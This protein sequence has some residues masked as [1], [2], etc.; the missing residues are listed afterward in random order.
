MNFQDH[1]LI[2]W[3]RVLAAFA[4]IV[5]LLSMGIVAVLGG[6]DFFF[7]QG[8]VHLGILA[9]GFGS[10]VWLTIDTEV[11]N[12]VVWALVG[13]AS[14]GA[15]F[16]AGFAV[17]V[18]WGH[19]SFPEFTVDVAE[20]LT[21]A[22]VPLPVALAMQPAVWAWLPVF[23]LILALGLLRF[24]DGKLPSSRWRWASRYSVI[25]MSLAVGFSIWLVRPS[26]TQS[27]L[28]PPDSAFD[29][30]DLQISETLDVLAIF[31]AVFGI[32]ALVVR[33][34]RSSGIVRRQ[35]R[36]IGWGAT[37]LSMAVI[38]ALVTE[39]TSLTGTGAVAM[40]AG[41]VLLIA[42]F[43]MAITKYRLYEI[44]V[45]VSRTV[46]YLSLAVVISALYGA[47][48]LA[49]IFVFGD[50]SQRGG[51]LGLT[52]PLG[53]TA[54]VAIVFEPIRARLQR[55]ANRIVYGR[56]AAP[57]EVLSQLTS[58][59]SDTS[60]GAGLEGLAQ[61]LRDGT[62][63]ETAVVW[64]RVAER[65]RAEASSPADVPTHP[66]DIGV[67]DDMPNSEFQLSVPVVHGGE[68]LGALSIAKPRAH[69]V[70]PA[71][72]DLLADVAAGAGLLLR[73]LRL[74]AELVQRA[75]QL[76][77]SRR[78]LI[79]AHDAARHRLERD[80]HDGAQQQVVALKVK[81]GL[82][83]N[84]AGREGA[85]DLTERIASLAAGTQEAVDAM[86]TVARGIYPPLLE[87]EGL[88][89]ALA[90][91][92]RTVQLQI[93]IESKDIPRYSRQVEETIYFC[94]L[95]ALNRG[96][97]AG[98]KSAEVKIQGDNTWLSVAVTF[99]SANGGTKF[100]ALE[101]RVDA[102]G[103]TLAVV[104]SEEGT[105]ITLQLP[106]AGEVLEST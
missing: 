18:V 74:N 24:P 67:D 26:V 93:R 37:F 38:W 77:G 83:Q 49:Y 14:F 27:V 101:D 41:E 47:A 95:A 76:Q 86:R 12:G 30:L 65:L 45:V 4:A 53:A 54:L 81:L 80:L 104:P 28:D 3:G 89:P 35:I 58:Q 11:R 98:A 57:T 8:V 100:T 73:N 92:T 85:A 43:A 15:L 56:R 32:A 79:A 72:E 84:L 97:M 60:A 1:T 44:D 36:W 78:R 82:A 19:G 22:G 68:L 75:D 6:W 48:V 46:A 88:G 62:A 33:Y 29:R 10:L 9:V 87:A 63:A 5:A 21:P 52:L 105:A 64:L 13:A 103:G 39:K 96:E 94:V 102:F 51:D 31:G 2:T 99:D 17:I 7:D 106:V 59:L 69:P 50:E 70:T 20:G 40:A 61:L 25:T 34:R 66:S 23:C 71:D 90:A 42:A 16:A 91:T 55:W